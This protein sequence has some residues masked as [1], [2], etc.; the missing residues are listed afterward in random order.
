MNIPSVYLVE[1]YNAYTAQKGG[2]KKHWHEIVEEQALMQRIMQ[3]Q[4]LLQEANKT[5]TLPPNSPSVASA[6]VGGMAAGA[7]GTP[8]P[9][10]FHPSMSFGYTVTNN[11]SSLTSSAPFNALYT[12]NGT[13]DLIALNAVSLLW[14][15]S[16][17]NT[18]TNVNPSFLY[19]TTGSYLTSLT[20]SSVANGTTFTI[21]GAYTI[22]PPTVNAAY[23]QSAYTAS[24]SASVATIGFTNNTTTNNASNVITYAWNFGSGSNPTSSLTNPSFTYRTTGLYS[25]ILAATGSFNITSSAVSNVLIQ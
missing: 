22:L 25:I 10:Y 8:V 13:M 5:P 24:L 12:L 14:N 3:E 18:S 11:S 9:V 19:T 7:G 4:M 20:A 1:P 15:F 23:N 6:T 17:S 21:S 2:R 16:G